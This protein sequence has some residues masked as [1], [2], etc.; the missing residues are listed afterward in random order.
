MKRSQASSGEQIIR[1]GIV[2]PNIGPTSGDTSLCEQYGIPE[3]ALDARLSLFAAAGEAA[4]LALACMPEQRFMA[5]NAGGLLRRALGLS[6]Q[7]WANGTGPHGLGRGGI[8]VTHR[9][10][11]SQKHT[12]GISIALQQLVEYPNR[13]FYTLRVATTLEFLQDQGAVDGDLVIPKPI[14]GRRRLQNPAAPKKA[15]APER[16]K[17]IASSTNGNK[18]RPLHIR[19]IAD[20]GVVG[21][22]VQPPADPDE[23]ERLERAGIV[24]RKRWLDL[25][26]EAQDRSA[27]AFT[28]GELGAQP[29][30]VMQHT[31]V[32]IATVLRSTRGQVVID[33]RPYT[34]PSPKAWS[35]AAAIL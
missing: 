35:S 31:A 29:A 26:E 1:P 14:S 24:N 25:G 12:D 15:T 2:I 32:L 13:P 21:L 19:S 23:Q 10:E 17:A 18:Q 28:R 34:H 8:F 3:V 4:V 33:G 11:P 9:A 7:D 27:F 5:K 6:Q 16:S 30:K 22:A 20:N